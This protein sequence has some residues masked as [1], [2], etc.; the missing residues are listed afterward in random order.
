MLLKVTYY[1]QQDLFDHEGVDLKDGQTISTVEGKKKIVNGREGQTKRVQKLMPNFIKR[2]RE[3]RKY[4]T[5][6]KGK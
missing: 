3:Y 5:D 2:H 6:V 1:E 4:A